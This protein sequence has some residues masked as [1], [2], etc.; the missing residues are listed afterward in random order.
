M[1]WILGDVFQV[2]ESELKI[3]QL[4]KS[5]D[6]LQIWESHSKRSL[7]RGYIEYLCVSLWNLRGWS[8]SKN[9]EIQG[10]K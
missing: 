6:H 10:E 1:S 4:E 3:N 5:T 9:S 8:K 2:N 7:G